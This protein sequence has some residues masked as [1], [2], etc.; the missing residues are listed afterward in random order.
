MASVTFAI[1]DNI[2]SEMKKMPWV[3]WSELAREEIFKRERLLKLLKQLESKEEQ[4]LIQWG[5]EL[6]RKSKK[7][8]FK[9]LLSE[10]STK[11]REELLKSF[12]PEKREELLK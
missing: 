10:L 12:T 1:P 6:G 9:K 4:E 11:K 7:G 5:V 8:R 3:N 2:K